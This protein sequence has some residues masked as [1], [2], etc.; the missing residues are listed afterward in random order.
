MK[1]LLITIFLTLSVSIFSQNQRFYYKYQFQTDSTDADSKREELM[2][3]D[4]LDK[5]SRY[6][7]ESVY[8]NDSVMNAE[9][10]KRVATNDLSAPI[11]MSDEH[12]GVVRSKVIKSYPDFS[13][14][15]L[16]NVS[17][18][19]YQVSEMRKLKWKI[20]PDKQKIGEWNTQKANT[21]FA[22]R[23]WTA[24]FAEE[25]P[26]QDGPYKFH[27]LPGLIIKMEDASKT[28]VIQ[29]E[30]IKKNVLARDYNVGF[31]G[32]E[33]KIDDKKLKSVYKAYW[34]DP[35]AG[36]RKMYT[37][38][39]VLITDES[40]KKLDINQQLI[41]MEKRSKENLKKSNNLLE[42]DL[43]PN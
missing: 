35:V 11:N 33:V 22:G 43:I 15:A 7:S 5:G 42:L 38:G 40:G 13:I 1:K 18:Q 2:S 24:W 41:D 16:V 30:A 26:I 14:T 4:I 25:I 9:F 12:R 32:Q 39:T 21:E 27:G 36:M 3:L 23:Q 8:L 31:M 19:D 34:K 17:M 28:H 6:Y 20:L 10:K 29:L 37:E